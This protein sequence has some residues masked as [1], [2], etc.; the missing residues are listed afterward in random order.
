M[1]LVDVGLLGGEVDVGLDLGTD[2]AQEP[3]VNQARNDGVLVWSRGGILRCVFVEDGLVKEAFPEARL[4]VFVGQRYGGSASWIRRGDKEGENT[5]V[6]GSLFGRLLAIS[7]A[8]CF[9]LHLEFPIGP[10]HKKIG[11]LGKRTKKMRK[12]PNK[13]ADMKTKY[14]GV[15]GQNLQDPHQLDQAEKPWPMFFIPATAA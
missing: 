11:V 5:A 10:S 13:W 3:I 9:P 7:R 8:I 4:G 14:S 15:S 6:L 1:D 12:L 2:F